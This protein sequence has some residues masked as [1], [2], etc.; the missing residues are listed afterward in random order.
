MRTHTLLVGVCC[1]FLAIG[2]LA[3]AADVD[4]DVSTR[5]TIVGLPVI[6]TIQITNSV[7][8]TPP[9]F[10]EVDGLEIESAGPP[11]RSRRTSIIN[12]RRTD[13]SIVVYSFRVTPL[14]EGTFTIPPIPVTA[15]D[16]TRLTKVVRI[17]ATKGETD[18][19]LFVEVDGKET[20]IYVGEP[21]DLTLKIWIRPFRDSQSQLRLSEGD[22]WNQVSSQ[23]K[24]GSF[25]SVFE[26]MNSNRQRPGGRSV[27]R[28]DSQ[29]NEREYY[30][31]EIDSKIYP[32]R[33]GTL[34]GG[35]IRVLIQYPQRLGRSRSPFSLMDEDD[36]FGPNSPFGRSPFADSFFN[37]SFFGSGLS[38]VESKP[39]VAEAVVDPIL[40]KP[41]PS[42]GRP[43]DYRGAVGQFSI[44]TEASPTSVKVG[45]PITLHIG[46]EGAGPLDVVLAP[47]I[48]S[49]Q[50]LVR[51]FKVPDEPLAGFV[52]RSRK[53]FSTSLRPL[54]SDVTEIPGIRFSYFD[55][56]KETFIT[57]TSDPIA[58]QVDQADML[59]L[60]SIVGAAPAGVSR[61]RQSDVT[62]SSRVAANEAQDFLLAI[63]PQS[64]LRSVPRARLLQPTMLILLATGPLS[65]LLA[66][67]VRSRWVI[68]RLIPARTRL[69]RELESARTPSDVAQAMERFLTTRF[70]LPE[71]RTR[72]DQGVGKLRA[73]GQHDLAIRLE[74]LYAACDQSPRSDDPQWVQHLGQQAGELADA[75]LADRLPSDRLR[76]L[77]QGAAVLLAGISLAGVTTV[78]SASDLE[79]GRKEQE[80][81]LR[82]AM[83]IEWHQS[84]EALETQLKDSLAKLQTLVDNGIEN[85]QLYFAL[86]RVAY[87]SGDLGLAVA[88]YRRALRLCPT[89]EL[90]RSSLHQVE[91]ELGLLDSSGDGMM[92]R[93][94]ASLRVIPL[95]WCFALFVVAWF[96]FWAAVALRLLGIRH[97]FKS[98]AA[99][100]LLFAIIGSASYWLG[101]ADFLRDDTVVLLADQVAVR[102]GDG[103]EFEAVTELKSAAGRQVKR[104]AE[105]G[106]W[107]EIELP[108]GVVG[109]I[110]ERS[111]LAVSGA[112][113]HHS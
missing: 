32:D 94:R 3:V 61:P 79:L 98:I 88:Y 93:I 44:V 14:R 57:V 90:Y 103:E 82:E 53:V 52:D 39:I 71:S 69:R 56:D 51:D 78:A 76:P 16:V 84:G 54:R 110:P 72:R 15:D 63:D 102:Q 74:R 48:E 29:G 81:L 28:Q 42:E 92:D 66:L 80:T 26:D 70:G 77:T 38:I 59:T 27:L 9:E 4:A 65:A 100:S 55:P 58:I 112:P 75:I 11:S 19:L 87:R 106:D 113:H 10:P 25:Q 1:C 23:S 111:A 30:L 41:V 40:V 86:A 18:D 60:D 5:E 31:Y 34:D 46:I 62:S 64:A 2:R 105:R 33:A 91:S 68:R 49:Q 21:L 101:I 50:N 36:F 8:H 6:L 12:N 17:I 13:Q 85:D 99:I 109:W 45:D 7:E 35:D 67:L 107:I 96:V 97:V 24:W 83:Q 37:D 104:L 108:S 20:E 22:M 95:G 43:G 89:N 47:P 73:A